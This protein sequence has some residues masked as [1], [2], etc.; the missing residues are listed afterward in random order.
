ML[1]R[2]EDQLYEATA[3]VER[4]KALVEEIRDFAIWMSG[5]YHF[6]DLD[7]YCENRHI[8]LKK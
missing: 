8:L 1:Y 4:L 3:E 7:Y 6:G 2:A 5:N